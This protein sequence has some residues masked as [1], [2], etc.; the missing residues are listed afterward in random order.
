MT[1]NQ[2]KELFNILSTLDSEVREIRSTQGE[3]SQ[4][5]GSQ[6]QAFGENMAV[7]NKQS[8]ILV[9]HS[10]ILNRLDAKTD[11]I[12]EAVMRHDQRISEVED[13]LKELPS[14]LH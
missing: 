6:T 8:R 13:E 2:G 14:G 5:F 11:T 10:K 9:E 7:L 12:A 1:D 3:H 4:I